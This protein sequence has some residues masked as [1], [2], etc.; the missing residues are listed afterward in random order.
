LDCS[1][2]INHQNRIIPMQSNDILEE[3]HTFPESDG[4]PVRKLDYLGYSP[5]P[6]RNEMQR[7]AHAF[8]REREAESGRLEWYSPGGCGSAND[9]YETMWQSTDE[10]DMPGVISDG[11]NSDFFRREMH[12]RWIESGVYGPI[13]RS[14]LTMR[15]EY[16]AAGAEDPLGAMNM[17]GAFPSVMMVDLTRLGSRPMPKRWEDLGNPIYKGDISISGWEDEIPDP[18]LFNTWK[19]YGEKGLQAFAK[20]IKNFWAPAQMAKTAGSGSTEGTAIYVLSLFFALANPRDDKVRIVWPEEGAWFTSLSFQAKRRRRPVS[21]LA[22]DFLTSAEWAKFLDKAGVP[23]VFAYPGQK[24]LP[25]MLSWVGWDFIR[26]NDL[27]VLRPRLN[28]VFINA[29]KG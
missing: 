16:A 14:G 26:N 7:R 23:A 29:R 17:Y 13:D 2:D 18:L 15:A 27:D 12:E 19:T 3:T 25:G 6:I 24:P 9:P 1:G 4:A 5:C 21:R 22:I 10:A 8:F 20:N 11:G 28:G